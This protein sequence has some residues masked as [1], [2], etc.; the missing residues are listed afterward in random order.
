[1]EDEE[2]SYWNRTAATQFQNK[3]ELNEWTSDL[4][5]LGQYTSADGSRIN[6]ERSKYNMGKFIIKIL[7]LFQRLL[8]PL[9]GTRSNDAFLGFLVHFHDNGM[10]STSSLGA[11]SKTSTAQAQSFYDEFNAIIKGKCFFVWLMGFRALP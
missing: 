7:F 1:M 6:V 10:A 3:I 4:E 5:V 11:Q 8:F 2:S 9:G